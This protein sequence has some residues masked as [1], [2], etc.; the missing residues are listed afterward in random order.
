MEV[1]QP[2]IWETRLV[3][4]RIPDLSIKPY[5]YTNGEQTR[6][7]KVLFATTF[8]PL[9]LYLARLLPWIQSPYNIGSGMDVIPKIIVLA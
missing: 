3:K 8:L 5:L 4:K 6:H 1:H 9:H 2:F 7:A